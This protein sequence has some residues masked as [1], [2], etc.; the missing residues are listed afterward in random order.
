MERHPSTVSRRHCGHGNILRLISWCRRYPAYA[1][2]C[3]VALLWASILG[4]HYYGTSQPALP[5][6]GRYLI[7]DIKGQ[8][9]RLPYAHLQIVRSQVEGRRELLGENPHVG[10]LDEEGDRLIFQGTLEDFLATVVDTI[11][12]GRIERKPID[13]AE[14]MPWDTLKTDHSKGGTMRKF[15]IVVP[16]SEP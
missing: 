8:V 10:F 15:D 9:Y 4:R 12:I 2:F 6:I 3:T 5:K 11:R 1:A 16:K 13:L 7:V 14:I